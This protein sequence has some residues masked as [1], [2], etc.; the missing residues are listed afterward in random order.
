MWEKI[1]C[2]FVNNNKEVSFYLFFQ[3][4]FKAK[5]QF[6]KLKFII[7]I[8]SLSIYIIFQV[9]ILLIEFCYLKKIKS[10]TTGSFGHVYKLYKEKKLW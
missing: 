7:I 8:K 5:S 9:F 1:Y 6:N 3:K 2:L 4:I 10:W